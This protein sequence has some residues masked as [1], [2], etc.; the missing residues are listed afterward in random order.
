MTYTGGVKDTSIQ[1]FW[2]EKLSF[3]VG[4]QAS[5]VLDELYVHGPGTHAELSTRC[6]LKVNVICGRVNEL[7]KAGIVEEFEKVL[8]PSTHKLVWNLRV[9]ES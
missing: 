9:K 1:A 4:K 8:D 2:E 5:R 3:R 6:D 7:L